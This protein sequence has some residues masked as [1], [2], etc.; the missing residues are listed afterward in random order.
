MLILT[1]LLGIV[2]KGTDTFKT[3]LDCL[4]KQHEFLKNGDIITSTSAF[5]KMLQKLS[6]VLGASGVVTT[7]R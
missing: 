6:P 1:L 4:S 7:V 2:D 5:L 3:F